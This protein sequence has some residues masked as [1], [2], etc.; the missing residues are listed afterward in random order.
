M[1]ALI[2]CVETNKQA[3]TDW[4]YIRETLRRFYDTNQIKY[5]RIYMGAKNKYKSRSVLTEIYEWKKIYKEEL[6]VI[7]CIDTD[8]YESNPVHKKELDEISQYCRDKGYE[9]VWFCHDIEEVYWGKSVKKKDKKDDSIRFAKTNSIDK[10]ESKKLCGKHMKA[11]YSNI[12]TVLNRLF[13]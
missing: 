4:V 9:L 13:L 11:K 5:G 3:N 1:K 8:R 6:V 2:F 7:Y 10:I 12:M